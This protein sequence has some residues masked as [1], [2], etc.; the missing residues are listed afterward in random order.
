VKTKGGRRERLARCLGTEPAWERIPETSHQQQSAGGLDGR[1]VAVKERPSEFV[2]S[3]CT[4]PGISLRPTRSGQA[5][6]GLFDACAHHGRE[7]SIGIDTKSARNRP[8]CVLEESWVLGA[9]R[10]C[11]LCFSSLVP[12]KE[13]FE[14]AR[15]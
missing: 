6:P 1:L 9:R 2:D 12:T 3:N 7:F 13:V 15:S 14:R 10:T 5:A 11:G 8:P 4:G